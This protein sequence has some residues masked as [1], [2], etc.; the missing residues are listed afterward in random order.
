MPSPAGL[1]GTAVSS[2]PMSATKTAPDSPSDDVREPER[3]D[4]EEEAQP[5][6]Q[7]DD[8]R[9]GSRGAAGAAREGPEHALLEAV[10]ELEDL[11]R[12]AA[13]RR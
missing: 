10:V 11:V 13:A 8:A 3:L 1:S 12:Q 5:L 2:D 6:G 9:S 4:H 7:P